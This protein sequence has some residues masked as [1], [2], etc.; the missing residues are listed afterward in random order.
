MTIAAQIFSASS[1][2]DTAR[3]RSLS[4]AFITPFGSRHGASKMWPIWLAV[5]CGALVPIILELA[6]YWFK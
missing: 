2:R 5:V 6:S 4:S 1:H 3:F